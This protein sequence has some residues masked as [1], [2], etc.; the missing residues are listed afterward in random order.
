V[1][2]VLLKNAGIG[3]NNMLGFTGETKLLYTTG[4]IT[5][6]LEFWSWHGLSNRLAHLILPSLVLIVVAVAFYGLVPA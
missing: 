1:L 3:L 6:G 5:P 2:A 4:E